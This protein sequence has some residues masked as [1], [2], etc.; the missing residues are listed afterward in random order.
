MGLTAADYLVDLQAL[1]PRGPAWP[2]DADA[3]L[4]KLLAALAEEFARIDGRAEALP[5]EA[6][7]QTT[8]ELLAD[9]ER[10][11]G[12]PDP[13]TGG[14]EP[15]LQGRR[16]ALVAKLAGSGSASI[17][18]FIAVALALGYEIEIHERRPFRAG[19]SS[20]G[21]PD[22]TDLDVFVWEVWAPETTIIEFRAGQSSAGEPLRSWGDALLECRINQLKPA[23]TRVLFIYYTPTGIDVGDGV[24]LDAGAGYLL[25]SE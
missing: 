6:N 22:Y 7:P 16:N 2:R 9:W 3:E 23:H 12:L 13:C 24:L 14:L 5:W 15:T 20:A 8:S 4:T 10:V 19:E 18:Y 17:A 21:D 11:A 25:I 1:L